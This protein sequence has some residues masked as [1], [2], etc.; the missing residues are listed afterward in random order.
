[1]RTNGKPVNIREEIIEALRK[2]IDR[3][4]LKVEEPS[5]EEGINHYF[6]QAQID[7]GRSEHSMDEKDYKWSI[8]QSYYS[9][10]NA[11][12]AILFKLGLRDQKHYV[13][14]DVLDELG[15]MGKLES[16][17]VD[18]FKAAMKSREDANYRAIYSEDT[19]DFVLEMAKEFLNRMKAL[20][21]ALN[22]K[23]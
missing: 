20:A 1:M 4:H 18:D 23:S 17:Y 2:T 16:K 8:V 19:A 14:A 5:N 9:I 21:N 22:G 10:F 12:R 6:E 7:L 11:A 15:K 13:I 3:G